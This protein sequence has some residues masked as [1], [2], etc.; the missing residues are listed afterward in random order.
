MNVVGLVVGITSLLLGGFAA[1]LSWQFYVESRGQNDRVQDAVIR[2]ETVVTEMHGNMVRIVERAVDT[3]TGSTTG[4]A[5]ETAAHDLALS[6]ENLKDKVENIENKQAPD[7]RKELSEL[8]ESYQ[9]KTENL[10]LA[11]RE[12]RVRSLVP[13]FEGAARMPAVRVSHTVLKSDN[14]FEEGEI[15]LEVSRPVPVI[16][17]TIVLS[18]DDCQN[19]IANIETITTPATGGFM[20]NSGISDGMRLNV[21]LHAQPG[22]SLGVGTYRLKYSVASGPHQKAR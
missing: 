1:W 12:S 6:L 4:S 3:W 9:N 10:I 17:G 14:N 2:I 18:I 22:G 20:V 19:P 8:I 5:P 16:T 7:I 21:H 11:L 13:T 15:T